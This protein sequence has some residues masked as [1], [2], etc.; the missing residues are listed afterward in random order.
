MRNCKLRRVDGKPHGS[1][2]W[3]PSST[4]RVL[5]RN[6]THGNN[7][8][9]LCETPCYVVIYRSPHAFLTA[10]PYRYCCASLLALLL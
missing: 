8:E 6:G 9:V 7:W 1:E 4:R 5:K 10:I 3:R 2:H